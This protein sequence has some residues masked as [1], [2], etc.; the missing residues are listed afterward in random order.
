MLYKLLYFEEA[1]KDVKEAKDW[2]KKKRNGLEKQFA[3]AIKH[4]IINI[5]ERPFSHAIRY[6]NVRIAHPN[7]FP[8]SIHYYVDEEK[9]HIVITA[10]VHNRSERDTAESRLYL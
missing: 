6:K 8:Y 7:I 5:S 3:A 2:Y 4:A 1:R 9:Q 10:I